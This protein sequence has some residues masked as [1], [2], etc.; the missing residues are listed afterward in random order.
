MR[1]RDKARHVGQVVVEDGREGLGSGGGVDEFAGGG[2]GGDGA[3]AGGPFLEGGAAG[4]EGGGFVG[5]HA[6]PEGRGEC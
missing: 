2:E 3:E 1:A 5:L 4:G 6:A